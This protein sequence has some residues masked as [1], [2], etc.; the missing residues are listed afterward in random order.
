M[1]YMWCDNGRDTKKV[2][3][4]IFQVLTVSNT[5]IVIDPK[6]QDFKP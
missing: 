1:A 3:K 6:C 4:L 2:T 5:T